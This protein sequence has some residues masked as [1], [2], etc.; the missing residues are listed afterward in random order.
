MS[1][2][3][4]FWP[5]WPVISETGWTSR[6]KVP[7]GIRLK[8]ARRSHMRVFLHVT[9]HRG[10]NP[11]RRRGCV[12]RRTSKHNQPPHMGLSSAAPCQAAW[13]F[14]L[15]TTPFF[16][17]PESHIMGQTAVCPGNTPTALCLSHT[18]TNKQ[19]PFPSFSRTA[20]TTCAFY[21]SNGTNGN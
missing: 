20:I 14:F 18:R 19:P 3:R 9:P 5:F 2:K 12:F 13:P 8:S 21:G 10:E 6:K 17:S 1:Q 4:P 16:G 15:Y 11:P 7:L